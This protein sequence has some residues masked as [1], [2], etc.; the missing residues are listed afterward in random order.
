MNKSL[1][2]AVT[3]VA[4]LAVT[5]LGLTACASSGDVSGSNSKSS[6]GGSGSITIGSANFPESQ[7]LAEIYAQALEGD[8]YKVTRNFNIGAREVYLKALKDGSINLI[9]E[10]TGNTLNYYVAQNGTTSDATDSDQIYAD[11]KKNL[12]KDLTVLNKS[13]AEDKDS[14]VVT[15]ET[16]DKYKL[17]SIEDLKPV[18]S[19]L[20][21]GAGAEFETRKAGLVGLKD[22]Y[23]IV[24]KSMTTLDSG[25]PLT[26]NAVKDGSVDVGD[27]FSTDPAI[28]QNHFVTLTDPK[29]V[30]TPQNVVPL[31][32]KA[33]LKGK[34]VD[35]LNAV[36]KSL[37][38][39]KLKSMMKDISI[40]KADIDTVA[41]KYIKDNK[42]N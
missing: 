26:V 11:L 32:T 16:A 28:E 7:L 24:F 4:L 12:P 17:K 40:D 41:K 36:S 21:M 9:P 3:A 37:T 14:L 8:G 30:F 33:V 23:G 1:R 35:A 13:A 27:I 31:G 39:D 2:R 25:G 10:Y 19:E 29:N 22:I 5:S 34:A 18:A 42:L 6:S 15:K 20:V 38:T